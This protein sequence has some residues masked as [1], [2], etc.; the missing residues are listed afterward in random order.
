[1]LV[2]PVGRF[3]L[4][5]SVIS[6]VGF[7]LVSSARSDDVTRGRQLWTD[8]D[9]APDQTPFSEITVTSGTLADDGDGTATLTTGG[10]GG[11]SFET[12]D[13]PAGTDPVAD[14][15]TDTL[16]ITETSPLVITGTAG[17]DTID[18]TWDTLTV[19]DGGTGA[20]SLTD[21]GILLGSGTGA[22]TALGVATNGQI[23][24]GDGT[25]DPVL[26]TITGTADEITVTNGVGSITLDIPDPLIVGKGGT[27]AATL[28][29]GGLLLGSGT[30]AITV[31][32]VAT[33]G[34]IPIGDG[35]TDPVLGTI[36]G[37]ANQVTVT[38][39]AGSITLSTPQDIATSSDVQF[40]DLIAEGTLDLGTAETFTDLDATPDVST[41]AYWNTNTSA[42]T[43][44]DFDGAGIAA[45]Q[46][47][48]VH[49]KGAITY[50]VTASG[51]NG[52]TTDI[53]TASGD[54]SAWQYDG[55]DWNL[56]AFMDDSDD[57]GAGGGGGG[58]NVSVDGAAVTDPDF[59]STGDIDF[60]DTANTVTA[61]INANAIVDGD[62]ATTETMELPI[63]SA[64]ITGA[65]V[66]RTPTSGDASTQGAQID[67]GD[68]NWRLLFD[69][70]TDE[71]AVWQ[72]RLPDYWAA[73]SE[74]NVFYTMTS[75]TT[76]E[77]EFEADVMCVSDGD[78]ADVG[79]A[80][81][82]GVAVGS[83]TVPGTAGYPDEISLTLTDDS[84]AAGDMM[85]VYLSTDAN[86]ATNDDATGDREVIGVEYEF[87]R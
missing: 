82:A 9:G 55:T 62:L 48:I 40:N 58:D 79:T 21:G 8:P 75:A 35:T 86:D 32:G 23:P 52:G 44:T 51:L 47:L 39:G 11:N 33:N 7:A 34:Q 78:A 41:G 14:S 19:G 81:F 68:G 80:S 17:T 72:F 26:A 50:D 31:L 76:L 46:V 36:T 56:I 28:T 83:A 12:I 45:G 15:A 53:V 24:I 10:G 1:M 13:V 38:N 4:L 49:S 57:I 3:R 74:L 42:V 27:G 61:N 63:Q 77:V 16:T 70:T 67:A 22:I 69:A 59:V 30:G 66:V 54:V 20:T 29:D 87:T 85:W 84:C 65:F 6:L 18:I 5:I 71:A 25:T 60:V 64:K 73:H 2:R 43:I 37:T